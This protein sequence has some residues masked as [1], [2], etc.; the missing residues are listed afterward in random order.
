MF[1]LKLILKFAKNNKQFIV[2]IVLFLLI[3]AVAWQQTRVNALQKEVKMEQNNIK[4]LQDTTQKYKNKSGELGFQ[5]LALQGSVARL[6]QLNDTLYQEIEKEKGK[7]ESITKMLAT[8][9][10]TDTVFVDSS[11]TERIELN[12][13]YQYK[14]KWELKKSGETWQKL[15]A[16]YHELT[17]DQNFNI[18]ESN[19]YLTSDILQIPIITGASKMDNGAYRIFVRTP[20][21]DITF[22][23]IQGAVIQP[24][25]IKTKD[26]FSVGLQAGYGFT[27]DGF[28]PYVGLGVQINLFSF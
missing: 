28:S 14:T 26:R 12:N 9:G 10:S 23:N 1:Y 22:S 5:K 7:V 24:N 11:Q 4:A 6:K 3:G 21:P 18:V 15:L 13:S 25:Q 17:I 20:Y 27:T 2:A 16:G 8:A 19:T